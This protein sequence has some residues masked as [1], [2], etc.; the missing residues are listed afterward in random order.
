MEA[1]REIRILM[2]RIDRPADVMGSHQFFNGPFED[3]VVLNGY[4]NWPF[5]VVFINDM[6]IGIPVSYKEFNFNLLSQFE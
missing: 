3:I 4:F 2:R 5:S 6:S 1:D